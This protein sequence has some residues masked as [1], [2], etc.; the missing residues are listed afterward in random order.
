MF[1]VVYDGLSRRAV[2]GFRFKCTYKQLFTYFTAAGGGNSRANKTT[3]RPK[4]DGSR[5]YT[6]GGLTT[7]ARA[8]RV[9]GDAT[10]SRVAR[11]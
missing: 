2:S 3:D 10:A 1:V 5:L 6:G 9:K 7:R 4:A 11:G 8:I